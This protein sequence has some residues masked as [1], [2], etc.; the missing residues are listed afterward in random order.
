MHC[1]LPFACGCP[2]SN[3]KAPLRR[4]CFQADSCRLCCASRYKGFSVA[5]WACLLQVVCSLKKSPCV[6]RRAASSVCKPSCSVLGFLRFLSAYGLHTHLHHVAEY[7]A[8]NHA[9]KGFSPPS[10]VKCSVFKHF[11]QFRPCATLRKTTVS[12]IVGGISL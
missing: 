10:I 12:R 1:R 5:L 2:Q 11:T 3:K 9:K 8:H 7:Q 4:S 6:E